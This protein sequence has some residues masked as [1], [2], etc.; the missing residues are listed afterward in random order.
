H[1]YSDLLSRLSRLDDAV[2]EAQ[3]A[4]QLDPLSLPI[5]QNLGDVYSV[6]NYADALQQY[7]KTLAIDANYAPTHTQLMLLYA[8]HA[9]Y[10]EAFSEMKESE[11]GL[12]E[13]ERQKFPLSF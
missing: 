6:L 12:N 7:R 1:W 8:S 13:A 10:E 9:K 2:T 4:V 5:N 3:R 11:F